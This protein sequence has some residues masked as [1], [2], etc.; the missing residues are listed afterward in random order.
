MR[1][2]GPVGGWETL[3]EGKGDAGAP[4]A[5]GVASVFCEGGIVRYE[6]REEGEG[7]RGDY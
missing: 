4:G 6:E 5:T 1:V 7:G 3:L 2:L